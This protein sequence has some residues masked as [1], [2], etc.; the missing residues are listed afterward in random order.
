MSK[1]MMTFAAPDGQVEVEFRTTPDGAVEV[2]LQGTFL[3]RN[4]RCRIGGRWLRLD[5]TPTYPLF[6]DAAPGWFVP[7]PGKAEKVA[8]QVLDEVWAQLQALTPGQLQAA[9]DGTPVGLPDMGALQAAVEVY[10]RQVR[11]ARTADSDDGE[12]GDVDEA[13]VW[14]VLAPLVAQAVAAPTSN[15]YT[16]EVQTRV[17]ECLINETRRVTASGPV[18][19]RARA[20]ADPRVQVVQVLDAAGVVAV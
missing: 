12:P 1:N 19:A 2:H 8:L 15:R 7:L 14:Q 3:A 5:R 11:A 10:V 9:V 20:A 18:E 6:I 13:E 4:T 17:G 16:V